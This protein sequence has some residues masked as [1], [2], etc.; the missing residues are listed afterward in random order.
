MAAKS[1]LTYRTLRLA[2][3]ALGLAC[4]HAYAVAG[5]GGSGRVAT[6]NKTGGGGN[7]RISTFTARQAGSK[8][9]VESFAGQRGRAMR[10]AS[11]AG[12]RRSS[13]SRAGRTDVARAVARTEQRMVKRGAAAPNIRVKNVTAPSATTLNDPRPPGGPGETRGPQARGHAQRLRPRHRADGP[14]AHRRLSTGSGPTSG[15]Q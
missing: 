12:G 14:R 10:S 3:I 8:S 15:R 2:T 6:V 9:G 11:N 13:P 7:S 4:F 5:P 1:K